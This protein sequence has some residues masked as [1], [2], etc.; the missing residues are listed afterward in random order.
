[1]KTTV[2]DYNDFKK[3]RNK[4]PYLDDSTIVKISKDT[5]GNIVY[6][7]KTNLNGI[8]KNY[9]EYYI[10]VDPKG[11]TMISWGFEDDKTKKYCAIY[12]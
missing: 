9:C 10:V 7:H 4:L 1:M 8:R 2:S 11:E 12:T 6:H 5:K 3:Y